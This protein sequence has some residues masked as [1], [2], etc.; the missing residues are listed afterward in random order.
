MSP[1]PAAS[2]TFLYCYPEEH[3]NLENNGGV[4]RMVDQKA[5][6]RRFLIA[7][8]TYSGLLSTGMGIAL[9]RASAVWARSSTGKSGELARMARLLF[10]HAGIADDVYAEVIDS[11]LSD[12][13]NDASMTDTL[14]I[15]L[16][17]LNTAQ[18]GDWVNASAGE[19][20]A[21]M[22]AVE[23]EAFFGVILGSVRVRFYNHPKVWEHI[24]Y[25]GS[26]V[27]HGGYVDRGF[28]DIDWLPGGA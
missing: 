8:I 26:S 13:A 14:N 20:I 3:T 19:Q 28:D 18:D 17:E 25:P 4:T 24:G 5:T 21:A 10:P 23:N 27:E 22:K 16:I 9:L 6:R 2:W 11:I 1:A 15:A 7:A 12:A